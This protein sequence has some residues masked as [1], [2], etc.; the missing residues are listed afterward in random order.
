MKFIYIVWLHVKNC[1]KNL[2]ICFSKFGEFKI[3]E[4]YISKQFFGFKKI[5]EKFATKISN[6][7]HNG[8]KEM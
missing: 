6:D 8:V 4:I 5:K 3:L 7:Y 1:C 2:A